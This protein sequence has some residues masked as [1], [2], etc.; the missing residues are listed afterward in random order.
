MT[1]TGL[2]INPADLEK[3][4]K[5]KVNAEANHFV[6]QPY[7]PATQPAIWGMPVVESSGIP[8]GTFLVGDFRRAVLF[9]REDVSISLGTVNDDFT[10]N[11]VRVLGELRA[12]FTVLRPKAFAKGTVP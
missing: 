4:D 7:G 10:R 1:P 8:A 6:R 5:L 9:D 12:G 2:V 3:V 11:I